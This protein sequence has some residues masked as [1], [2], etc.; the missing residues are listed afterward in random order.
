MESLNGLLN[1]A[2]LMLILC[3]IYDAFRI[4]S[5]SNKSLREG[6]TGAL[7]GLICITVML[8]HWSFE[9][10]LYFDVRSVLL[11]LSGLFFGLIPTMIAVVIVGAFRLYQGGSGALVG[12]IVIVVTACAGLAWRYWKDKNKKPLDWAQLYFFGVVAHLG[13]LSC[14]FLFPAELRNSILR[15]SALPILLIYPALTA[16]IGLIL[17]RQEERQATEKKLLYTTSLATAAL[18][19]TPDGILIVDLEGKIAHWNQKFVALWHVPQHLL[20]L[21]DDGPLLAY[22]A[23]QMANSEDFT[24]KVTELYEHP[25]DS[26]SDTLY[27]ADGRIFER[28]S[29][30]QQVGEEVVGRFWSF[31]DITERKSA[32]AAL[33]ESEKRYKSLFGNSP[34]AIGI[35]EF[36]SGKMIEV[37][38]AWLKLSGYERNDVIGQTMAELGLYVEEKEQD[39]IIEKIQEKGRILNHTTQYKRKSGEILDI[40]YSADM[41]TLDS[42]PYLQVITSDISEQKRMEKSLRQ[43]EFFFKES[44][45]AAFVGSYKAD[46]IAGKWES[47]E[48]LDQIFGIDKDYDRTIQGWMDIVHPDDRVLMDRYLMEEVISNHKPFSKEYRIIRINDGET[49][50]VNGQ[51]SVS[52]DNNGN[53]VALTGTIQDITERKEADKLLHETET[54]LSLLSDNI[55][56]GL[57]YQ[58]D[59]GVDGQQR[60]FTYISASAEQLHGVTREDVLHDAKAIYRQIVEEDRPFLVELEAKA[61]ASM[62]PFRAEVRM[63][64]QS[65]E[66]R[67]RL[68]SSAPRKLDNN[69]I[70]WDGIEVDITERKQAEQALAENRKF[71]SDLIENSGTIIYVKDCEGSYLLVNKKFEEVTGIKRDYVLNKKDFE[72]FPGKVGKQ[73]RENDLQVMEQGIAMESEETLDDGNGTRH[74]LS[75]KFPVRDTSNKVKGICGM[76]AEITRR[77]SEEDERKKNLI[78]IEELLKNAPVGIRVFNGESGDCVLINQTAADISGGDVESMKRQNFRGLES[79]HTSGLFEVAEAVLIDGCSRSVESDMLTSFGKKVSVVYIVSKFVVADVPHLLIIGRDISSEKELI[80]KNMKIEAQMLHAQKLESLGILAGGIAHDFNN[81]LLAILGNAELALMRLVPESPATNNLKQIE[82]AAQRAADLAQQMLAYSGKGQFIV[83]GLDINVL[84]TEMNHILEVSISKK[85]LM[86]L[87]LVKDLPLFVGDAT[88]IRQI[89]MNLVINASEA[90]VEAEGFITITTGS[91]ECDQDFLSK[92]WLFDELEAGPYVYFEVADTGCGMGRETL[93]KIFD[94][95]F[96]TKFTGRGLGMAAVLGIVRG[97]RGAITV[98][99]E[100]GKGTCFKVYLPAMHDIPKAALREIAPT[101]HLK[102][103]AGVVLL[104]DDEETILDLGKEM[105]E[106]LGYTA[107]IAENGEA[108]LEIFKKHGEEISCII[109]DLIMP[110]LDGEQTLK[111]LQGIDPHVKVIMS[112]GYNEHDVSQKFIGKGLAGFIQKPYKLSTLR[113]MIRKT[114]GT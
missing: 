10:G 20:D 110:R 92:I 6:V 64:L 33:R 35:C 31:R 12:T 114:C 21:S 45:R 82:L 56:D 97:H 24:A 66:I 93:E 100:P 42:R 37:N 54:R 4:S 5:I 15:K 60:I 69:H 94:P 43:S 25:N 108:A 53:I 62:A 65:G 22:V 55:P 104:V 98:S 32:E 29:Q 34:V 87:N 71:L 46:F 50:W 57:V 63:R 52:F 112:S 68:F 13:M 106:E 74:F 107:L 83:E 70:I 85:I 44:Q 72:L 78:F 14:M 96:T 59:T 67:W 28:Y 86:R 9:N 75:V 101:E 111:E 99:S 47:S 7:V 23:S 77:K 84:I 91:L 58:V 48:V 49:R 113:D 81:I 19:S 38:D 39:Q 109:L 40:L 18:E 80:E 36:H 11:S 90:I 102:G 89:I 2:A 51:G 105:L 3:V 76:S 8:N 16:I 73:F 30:P 27:L 41:I 17:K 95:F 79:W 1:N 103:G 61:I 26:S 88:Q